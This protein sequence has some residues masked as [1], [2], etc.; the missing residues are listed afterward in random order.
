MKPAFKTSVNH[1]NMKESVFLIAYLF[2]IP[3]KFELSQKYDITNEFINFRDLRV[4]SHINY[5]SEYGVIISQNSKQESD[6]FN[7]II[8]AHKLKR[9]IR[10]DYSLAKKHDFRSMFNPSS[11]MINFDKIDNALGYFQI[12]TPNTASKVTS[13]FSEL[14][15]PLKARPMFYFLQDDNIATQNDGKTLEFSLSNLSFFLLKHIFSIDKN[16]KILFSYNEIDKTPIWIQVVIHLPVIVL[17]LTIFTLV[18]WFESGAG[19]GAIED[20]IAK[21]PLQKYN[22]NMEISECSICLDSFNEEQDVRIL[23]CKHCFHQNCIDSWLR[24][25]L[26][27]PICRASV[28][29]L[30]ESSS[31][32]I[33]QTINSI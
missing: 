10:P 12:G 14:D 28:S 9:L 16:P 2:K 23:G 17:F 30:T 5:L 22:S 21:L 33:Y 3:F 1:K 32:Q 31:Y 19:E 18:A 20:E 8:Y 11:L 26:R 6:V 29:K 24:N 15:K 13:S 25:M 4:Q 27:C 7:V